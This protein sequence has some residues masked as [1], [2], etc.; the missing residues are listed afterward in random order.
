MLVQ[1]VPPRPTWQ[2]E[3][4]TTESQAIAKS[5]VWTFRIRSG[6]TARTTPTTVRVGTQ[7]QSDRYTL[8][9]TPYGRR[10]KSGNR[11]LTRKGFG[12]TCS[13]S[14]AYPTSTGIRAITSSRIP[15]TSRTRKPD[16]AYLHRRADGPS[17][18]RPFVSRIDLGV[19]DLELSLGI[20]SLV[21][22]A[23]TPQW[24]KALIAELPR[25]PVATDDSEHIATR[26]GVWP[27]KDSRRCQYHG[28]RRRSSMS[29][30]PDHARSIC[31]DNPESRFRK[32]ESTQTRTYDALHRSR[33]PVKLWHRR[34]LPSQ[35][36]QKP[37]ASLEFVPRKWIPRRPPWC[38]GILPV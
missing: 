38:A 16:G 29:S 7:F 17:I 1:S 10:V 23:E 13:M 8:L 15:R 22:E 4:S 5:V 30:T 32:V 36:T 31:H 18:C 35:S 19:F 3:F 34:T 20:V 25:V 6:P 33:V 26:T 37:I 24:L 27:Q 28:S 11:R 12:N 21:V 2:Q 9:T 14:S